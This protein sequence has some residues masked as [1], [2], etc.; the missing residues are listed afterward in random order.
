VCLPSTP[1]GK[2]HA[3]SA[4]LSSSSSSSEEETDSAGLSLR[5]SV[6]SCDVRGQQLQPKAKR[7]GRCIDEAISTSTNSVLTILET[8]TRKSFSAGVVYIL[9]SLSLFLSQLTAGPPLD[10]R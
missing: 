9:F 10:A 5:P 3:P 8:H 7:G 2:M 1:N 4:F 6:R